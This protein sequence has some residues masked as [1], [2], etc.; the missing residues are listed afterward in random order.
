MSVPVAVLDAI[1]VTIDAPPPI[2][3]Q[4]IDE[5]FGFMSN[6]SPHTVTDEVGLVYP[7]SEHF[8]QAM[9]FVHTP[10]VAEEIR[11]KMK[12]P[13]AAATAGRSR[14]RPMRKD[15]DKVKDM[16]METAILLKFTQHADIRQQ[17][18]GTQ[19]TRL[20]EHTAR[21]NYWGDGGDKGTGAVG[22]NRLGVLLEELRDYL[23]SRDGNSVE[24]VHQ[25]VRDLME[26][27]RAPPADVEELVSAPS[28]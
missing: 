15:W 18:L 28:N 12:T 20:V 9:K 22:K 11:S 2:L 21:D 19:G 7:T 27:I 26:R 14:D 5:P 6:F 17:L 16:V 10:V 23:T 24:H 25:R 3:F 1:D 4:K 8:F 13:M